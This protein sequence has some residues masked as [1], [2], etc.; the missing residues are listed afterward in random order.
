M[1]DAPY[2]YYQRKRGIFSPHDSAPFKLSRTKIDL[3]RECPRCFYLDR[4][5][6]LPRTSFPAFTLNSA[7]DNL[8]K[9]EFDQYRTKG[10]PHPLMVEHG[11]DAVPFQHKDLDTWRH[12]FTGV[13]A[14]HKPT[15]FLVFGAVD[16]IWVKPNGELIVVDYKSTS[17]QDAPTLDGYWQEAYK[18]QMEV[19]QWLLRQNGFTVDDTGYFVY[20]N[21]KSDLPSFD[22]KLEFDTDVLSHT[23]SDAWVEDALTRAKEILLMEAVPPVGENCEYC[24]YRELTGKKLIEIHKQQ[25]GSA[26][27][28]DGKDGKDEKKPASSSRAS[29]QHTDSQD[30]LF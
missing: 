6:G 24:A 23:G 2:G 20:V 9:N 21:G 26:E 29:S 4:R 3:S 15:N 14:I 7:V 22:G 30:T 17:K 28:K 11:I 19:Y 16:D 25:K 8:L 5:H 12:N 10:K 18:R 1:A 13:Q 27:E